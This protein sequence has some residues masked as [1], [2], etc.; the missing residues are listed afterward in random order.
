MG[1]PRFTTKKPKQLSLLYVSLKM[2]HVLINE[3]KAEI[4]IDQ[5][6]L[7]I[8]TPK[9]PPTFLHR[10]FIVRVLAVYNMSS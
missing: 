1:E 2:L 7:T 5:L 9:K 10:L 3:D 4:T 6:N 8:A